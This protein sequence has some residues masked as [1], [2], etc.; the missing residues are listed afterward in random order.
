MIEVKEIKDLVREYMSRTVSTGADYH[1]KWPY[2]AGENLRKVTSFARMDG[3]VICIYAKGSAARS[4]L[5]LEKR[6]GWSSPLERSLF[7]S[8]TTRKALDALIHAIEKSIP[9]FRSYMG[10]KAR[11]LGLEKL[12]WY[13][14]MAPVTDHYRIFPLFF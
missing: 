12:S 6:R 9:T 1:R 5:M 3:N 7:Q 4:R 8:R 11:L 10:V 14:I 2:I 13:D